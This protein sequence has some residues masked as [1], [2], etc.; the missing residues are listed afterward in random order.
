M[1]LYL[2]KHRWKFTLLQHRAPVC[3]QRSEVCVSD[4]ISH[5]KCRWYTEQESRKYETCLRDI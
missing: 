1:A 4:V 2:V 5:V 3:F